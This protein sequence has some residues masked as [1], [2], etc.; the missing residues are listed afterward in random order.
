MFIDNRVVEVSNIIKA[1]CSDYT[2]Y[3]DK[4]WRI[5]AVDSVYRRLDRDKSAETVWVKNNIALYK[6]IKPSGYIAV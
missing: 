1:R 4:I 3:N 5:T 2:V 6:V